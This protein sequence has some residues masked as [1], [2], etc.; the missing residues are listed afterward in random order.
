MQD[1]DLEVL[2]AVDDM[3]DRTEASEW[4]SP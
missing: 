1:D 3:M 4:S 2:G